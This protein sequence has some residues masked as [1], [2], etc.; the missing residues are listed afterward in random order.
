M[1][2]ESVNEFRKALEHHALDINTRLIIGT[3]ELDPEIPAHHLFNTETLNN[4]VY[5]LDQNG[6]LNFRTGWRLDDRQVANL[7]NTGNFNKEKKS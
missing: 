1:E 7:M 4:C 5:H 3:Y 2:M 6:V